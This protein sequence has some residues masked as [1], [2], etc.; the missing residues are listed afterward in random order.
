MGRTAKPTEIIGAI[1]GLEEEPLSRCH[2]VKI[3]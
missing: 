2:V 1:L 3:E